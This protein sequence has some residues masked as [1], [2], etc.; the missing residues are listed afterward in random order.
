MVE[1]GDQDKEEEEEDNSREKGELTS[2][3]RHVVL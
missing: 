3:S 1:K 2:G